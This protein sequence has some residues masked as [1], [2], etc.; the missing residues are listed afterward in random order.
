MADPA[1]VPS[2]DKHPVQPRGAQDQQQGHEH[3]HDQDD[4][5]GRHAGALLG[6]GQEQ[7][8]DQMAR[9]IGSEIVGVG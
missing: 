1:R 3:P 9:T 4:G 2:G 8:E 6:Q 7:V 5:V